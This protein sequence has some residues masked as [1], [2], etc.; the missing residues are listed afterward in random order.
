MHSIKHHAEPRLFHLIKGRHWMV[1]DDEEL[2][3]AK[4]R[5]AIVTLD[6]PAGERRCMRFYVVD[7]GDPIGL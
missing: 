2:S 1:A 6:S 5:W 7:P 3:D 4:A